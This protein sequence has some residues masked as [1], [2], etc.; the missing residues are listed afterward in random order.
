MK[1][2]LSKPNVK[3]L[4]LAHILQLFTVSVHQRKEKD[5]QRERSP[6]NIGMCLHLGLNIWHLCSIKLCKVL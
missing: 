4:S 1:H 5:D 2:I 3:E 6:T